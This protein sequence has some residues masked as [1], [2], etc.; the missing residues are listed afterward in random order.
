M[1][2]SPALPAAGGSRLH[3]AAL[4]VCLT[5]LTAAAVAVWYG[6]RLV[7]H[8]ALAQAR[9]KYEAAAE[10]LAGQRESL[11]YRAV[12]EKVAPSVVNINARFPG[13][14]IYFR[15][16]FGRAYRQDTPGQAGQG[17][18]VLVRAA[19]E[20][21]DGKA[22]VFVLTNNHV[23]TLPLEGTGRSVPAESITL[24]ISGRPTPLR[25]AVFGLDAG[26]DLALLEILDAPDDLIA[27]EPGDSDRA[28]VGDVVLAFGSPFGLAQSVTQGIISAKGRTGVVG[29][30]VEFLQTSA[31]VNPGNSGGPLVDMAGKVIGINTAIISRSGGSHGIGFAVPINTA[32]RTIEHFLRQGRLGPDPVQVRRGRLG[33]LTES[34]ARIPETVRNE[35]RIPPAGAVV[36]RVLRGSPA[37]K[38][39]LQP[40]DTITAVDGVAVTDPEGLRAA[41]AESKIGQTVRLTVV[42]MGE[43]MSISAGIDELAAPEQSGLVR[44]GG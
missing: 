13:Q 38:A 25:A 10:F 1:Q 14:S 2:P 17:S 35:L 29:G 40:G 27:A 41:V 8:Y 32:V 42:R 33:V 15:D 26:A 7:E 9:G 19:P 12:V 31:A 37:E 23:V 5:V 11:T 18:G 34:P 39:R 22:R 3:T 36:V 20:G 21:F 30:R 4:A 43:T 28:A 6:P 44:E 16:W 24:D